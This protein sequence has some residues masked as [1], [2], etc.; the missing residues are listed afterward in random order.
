MSNVI[1]LNDNAELYPRTDGQPFRIYMN[2]YQASL[3]STQPMVGISDAGDFY[4][5]S[6]S[7]SGDCFSGWNIDITRKAAANLSIDGIR[8]S[9]EAKEALS[10][11]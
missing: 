5:A 3:T 8:F 7:S 10:H 6:V 2:D 9:E 1:K 11:E 4:M